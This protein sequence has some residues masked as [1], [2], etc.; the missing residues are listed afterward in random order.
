MEAAARTEA[1]RVYNEHILGK[2]MAYTA[3]AD[4]DSGPVVLKFDISGGGG[5]KPGPF[6]LN[7][8]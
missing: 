5:K 2:N 3:R 7:P 6:W 4:L 1:E 8:L